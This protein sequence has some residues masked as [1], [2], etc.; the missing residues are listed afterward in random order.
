MKLKLLGIFVAVLIPSLAWSACTGSSPTWTTTPDYASVSA[1]V[2]GATVGDTINVS[3]GSATW[4][5]TLNITKGIN[6]IGDGSSSTIIT[7][8]AHPGIA[9]APPVGA[10]DNPFRL[11]GFRF[12]KATGDNLPILQW[13]TKD[14]APTAI[15]NN[16]L[17]KGR[18]DHCIFNATGTVNP[19]IWMYPGTYGVF[20]NNTFNAYNY[21]FRATDDNE[22][23]SAGYGWEYWGW[24]PGTSDAVYVENNTFNFT[25]SVDNVGTSSQGAHRW[26]FRYNTFNVNSSTFSFFDAHGNMNPWYSSVQVSNI[27]GNKFVAGNHTAQIHKQRGGQS[28]AFYNDWQTTGDTPVFAIQEEYADSDGPGPATNAV[29]GQ[30]QH[31]YNSYYFNNRVNTTG[32]L[33]DTAID[34]W[35]GS[36]P[37]DN[38][39]VWS[40]SDWKSDGSA[41]VGCGTVSQMNAITPTVTGVGFWATNQSCTNLTNYVGTNPATPIS[42]TLY[43]WNGSA[44]VSYYTPYTYPHPLRTVTD[45]PTGAKATIGS[46]AAVTLGSGAV[47][48]LY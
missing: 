12:N 33:I 41:G 32:T 25:A 30:P 13:G 40:Q 42:G 9:Y 11:S 16:K 23:T 4:D 22:G 37:A 29:T 18:V 17:T 26:V 20:D 3:S 38:V 28:F 5:S 31:V 39:D 1:C 48:T 10:A 21:A 45:P 14:N 2:S 24:T 15:G 46:G 44:W 35:V 7:T 34:D 8:T 36:I 47:G 19:L 27:Y 43:R 6:L